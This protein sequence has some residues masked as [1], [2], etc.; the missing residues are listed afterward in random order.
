MRSAKCARAFVA[1]THSRINN[2]DHAPFFHG[3]LRPK[4]H[5]ILSSKLRRI[6]SASSEG[7]DK[8]PQRKFT[9]PTSRILQPFFFVSEMNSLLEYRST[10]IWLENLSGSILLSTAL[11]TL[12]LVHGTQADKQL[13]QLPVNLTFIHGAISVIWRAE[14]LPLLSISIDLN[15]T[16]HKASPTPSF[17]NQ[18]ILDH[19]PKGEKCRWSSFDDATADH[20]PYDIRSMRVRCLARTE[21]ILP[22]SPSIPAITRA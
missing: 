6:A 14:P 10:G 13:C 4:S 7:N 21:G 2:F 22:F 15:L 18:V 5:A 16:S 20:L 3:K 17:T 1:F 9:P 11:V 19:R 12:K 8:N